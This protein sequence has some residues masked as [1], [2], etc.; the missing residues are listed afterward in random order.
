[1]HH[2]RLTSSDL[3]QAKQAHKNLRE[4]DPASSSLAFHRSEGWARKRGGQ[5]RNTVEDTPDRIR[6]F[7]ALWHFNSAW[8][9]RGDLTGFYITDSTWW[10]PFASAPRIFVALL[11]SD[12]LV[13]LQS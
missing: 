8:C 11:G 9:V 4:P 1:M 10:S 7:E 3:Q 13:T 5:T 12:L 2:E 6:A